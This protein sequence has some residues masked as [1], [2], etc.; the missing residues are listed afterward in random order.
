[1]GFYLGF[2]V[3]AQQ[4]AGMVH[5]QEDVHERLHRHLGQSVGR[6]PGQY[7]ERV[8][9]PVQH[10]G[11]RLPFEKAR[12]VMG[13]VHQKLL[14]LIIQGC[15]LDRLHNFV[16]FER[17]HFV[18][19]SWRQRLSLGLGIIPPLVLP[20]VDSMLLKDF[21]FVAGIVIR[22]D[23]EGWKHGL[24]CPLD[25]KV[26]RGFRVEILEHA[27]LDL[28]EEDESAAEGDDSSGQVGN[29]AQLTHSGMVDFSFGLE[30]L[31]KCT[32][33]MHIN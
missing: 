6:R 21:S 9:V 3:I 24:S 15:K 29:A 26:G 18:Q 17:R 2:G 23:G 14:R 7:L 12:V 11:L 33:V 16:Q 4:L 19:L 28:D 30:F 13:R 20:W 22:T 31:E 25:S 32:R 5:I 1:M 10:G 27:S 8:A